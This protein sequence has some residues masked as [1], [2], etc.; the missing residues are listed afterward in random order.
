M[1]YERL[2]ELRNERKISQTKLA[3]DMGVSSATVSMWEINLR[4]MI[5]A[6]VLMVVGK[7]A[8]MA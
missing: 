5:Y 2:K 6:V 1:F 7:K 4:I 8:A 3:R